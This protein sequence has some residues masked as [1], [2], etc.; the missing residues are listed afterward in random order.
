MSSTGP[1]GFSGGGFSGLGG[2]LSM[3]LSG[4]KAGAAKA[5]SA[6]SLSS[7]LPTSIP[8]MGQFGSAFPGASNFAKVSASGAAP[9]TVQPFRMPLSGATATTASSSSGAGIQP[10]SKAAGIGGAP[11][12]STYGNAPP[13]GVSGSSASPRLG[14]SGGVG[15]GTVLPGGG[16]GSYAAPGLNNRPTNGGPLRPV[17]PGGGAPVGMT[18]SG[19]PTGTPGDFRKPGAGVTF[20]DQPATSATTLNSLGL[21]SLAP[22]AAG[23]G[24]A[25]AV[26][27]SSGG[28]IR[29]AAQTAGVSTTTQPGVILDEP[30]ASVP[31]TREKPSS[32]SQAALP[33]K[34][35]E[36]LTDFRVKTRQDRALESGKLKE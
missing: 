19:A 17:P 24:G 6:A 7:H 33:P 3:N 26:P 16:T 36:R 32:E 8:G 4:A 12:A 14:A 25:P 27:R 10:P 22:P 29:P 5:P 13:G 11:V 20:A 23:G 30:V 28:S 21:G 2:P 31:E 18:S 9:V 1:G 15:F 35:E 34:K